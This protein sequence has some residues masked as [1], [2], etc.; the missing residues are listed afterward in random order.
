MDTDKTCPRIGLSVLLVVLSL[1]NLPPPISLAFA[2]FGQVWTAG[3]RPLYPVALVAVTF[4]NSICTD[5]GGG[6]KQ[7][8]LSKIRT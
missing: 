8:G 3:A 7:R 1:K 2:S 4:P 6:N 5:R